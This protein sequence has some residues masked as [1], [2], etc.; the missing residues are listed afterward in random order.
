MPSSIIFFT[1]AP[2]Y[3]IHLNNTI[4]QHRIGGS[5]L[6]IPLSLPVNIPSSCLLV[7]NYYPSICNCGMALPVNVLESTYTY[8][9]LLILFVVCFINTLIFIMCDDCLCFFYSII[10]IW[11]LPVL[12]N[13]TYSPGLLLVRPYQRVCRNS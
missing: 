3:L 1:S 6:S 11:W 9:Q 12:G 2:P 8:M 4:P 13:C 7:K 5:C 10:G